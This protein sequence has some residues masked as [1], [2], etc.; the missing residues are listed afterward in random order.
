MNAPG[1]VPPAPT[2]AGRLLREARERQGLH[3]AALAASIKVP[4]KKLEALEQDRHDELPDATFA[5]ALAQTVC[6]ALKID[7]QPVLALLPRGG[8]HRLEQ[9]S[10][11]LNTPFRERSVTLMQAEGPELLRNPALWL[12]LVVLVAAAAVWLWPA[13]VSRLVGT[14]PAA[15]AA[16]GPAATASSSL[17]LFPPADGASGVVLPREVEV[18][19]P[20]GSAPAE[21][22]SSSTGAAA[23]GADT[24]A[25]A[26]TLPASPAASAS[27]PVPAT[28]ASGLLTLRT[29]APSWIEVVDARGQP[30]VSRLLQ[31]GEAVGV[32][33]T[34][35]LR[36]RIGNAAVTEVTFRGQPTPLAPHTRDNVARLELR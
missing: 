5:R 20:A 22:G 23:P 3:I 1:D 16:A 9:V 35:P 34:P 17:P 27:V 4:P 13:S 21:P 11:G 19:P 14:S 12:T 18:V 6:R 10:E 2:S 36:L 29:A 7:A 25:A 31:A 28:A 32:D 24:A 15:S 8:A 30:L 33:G 26:A